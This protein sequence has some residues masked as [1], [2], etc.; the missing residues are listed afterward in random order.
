MESA[1]WEAAAE[2]GMKVE[3]S[4]AVH[5]GLLPQNGSK[6]SSACRGLLVCPQHAEHVSCLQW[7]DWSLA[8]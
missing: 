1:W 3:G 5:S 7:P 8:A 6:D 2:H 4:K